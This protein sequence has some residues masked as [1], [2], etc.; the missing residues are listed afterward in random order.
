[1]RK[2]YSGHLKYQ[3]TAMHYWFK[4]TSGFKNEIL[5]VLQQV[6]LDSVIKCKCVHI[7]LHLSAWLLE[8]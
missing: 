4:H 1:M 7:D 2:L 6:A 3:N 5:L 8:G